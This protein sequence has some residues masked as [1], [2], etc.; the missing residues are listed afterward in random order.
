MLF[1][2]LTFF[3]PRIYDSVPLRCD[4]YFL[5][6]CFSRGRVC[7]SRCSHLSHIA[8]RKKSCHIDAIFVPCSVMFIHLN[9]VAAFLSTL[10]QGLSFFSLAQ[11]LSYN[12][13]W[14]QFQ[15]FQ[16]KLFLPSH[17][18]FRHTLDLLFFEISSLPCLVFTQILLTLINILLMSWRLLLTSPG[19]PLYVM[20][21]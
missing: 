4:N 6:S 7:E 10:V 19:A 17:H 16:I 9:S 14:D 15:L 13:S 11:S 8:T 1:T 2:W 18:N 12:L 21:F 3:F 5:T 20:V